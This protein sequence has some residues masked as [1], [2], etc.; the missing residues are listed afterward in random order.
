M[1]KKPKEIT[2]TIT[3]IQFLKL[4]LYLPYFIFLPLIYLFL[5]DGE[6]AAIIF[7]I[8]TVILILFCTAGAVIGFLWSFGLLSLKVRCH[9]CGGYGRLVGTGAYRIPPSLDC[10]QC[11]AVFETSKLF[12]IDIT[13]I[14]KDP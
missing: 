11:C 13:K 2:L 5:Q 14:D 9:E 10:D 1:S 4:C 8:L 12:R 7:N 6:Q 3:Y